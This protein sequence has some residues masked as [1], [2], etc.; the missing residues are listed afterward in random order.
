M[1]LSGIRRPSPAMIVSMI[2]LCFA[3][4]GTAVAQ[5][6]LGKITKSKVKTIANKQI[7]K[8]APGLSV[9]SAATATSATTATNAVNAVNATNSSSANPEL[10]AH[11]DANGTV[12]AAHS[13]GITQAEVVK[14]AN[15]FGAY[16]FAIPGVKGGVTTTDFQ[17]SGDDNIAR[18]ALGALTGSTG[19]AAGTTFVVVTTDPGSP[20]LPENAGFYVTAWK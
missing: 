4:V 12:D 7:S 16:C 18:F 9:K 3:L 5:D 13:K 17:D 19:C 11:V 15:T 20:G 14:P 6:S 2:A 10:Y 1:Y 8:A